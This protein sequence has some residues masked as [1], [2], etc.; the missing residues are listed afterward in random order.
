MIWKTWAK[1]VEKV[2]KN[3]KKDYKP[4]IIIPSMNGGLVPCAIIASTLKIKD[5]RPVSIGRKNG[6]RLFLYPKNGN[7]GTVKNKKLLIIEDDSLTGL[8]LDFAQKTYIKQGAR[9]VRVVCIFKKRG[10]VNINY[11]AKSVDK[12]PPYPWKK[13]NF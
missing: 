5:I 3:I 10:L 13:S 6:Q 9:E 7:I 2:S 11:F 1:L 8:T 4:D 12:F